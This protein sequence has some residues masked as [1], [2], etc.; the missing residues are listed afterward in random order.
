MAFKQLGVGKEGK[1][2]INSEDKR[3]KKAFIT[4]IPGQ[5]GT[6]FT[7]ICRTTKIDERKRK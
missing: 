7:G 2:G 5:E 4:G 6:Y 1:S 3:M